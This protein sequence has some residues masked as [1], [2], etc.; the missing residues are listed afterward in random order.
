M[1]SSSMV[2]Q[3][4]DNSEIPNKPLC[5][6][7]KLVTSFTDKFKLSAKNSYTLA[8]MSPA[9]VP[10]T[11]PSN[12]VMPI[13]VSTDLPF[14]MAATDAPLPKCATTKRESLMSLPKKRAASV[15]TKR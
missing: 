13:D 6:F 10:I 4:L 14:L 1:A 11:K 5:L 12:G 9:R 15:A 8:S 2:R 3:S 7:N